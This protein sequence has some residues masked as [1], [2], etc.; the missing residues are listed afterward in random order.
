MHNNITSPGSGGMKE[1]GSSRLERMEAAVI[2]AEE[3]L[4][5]VDL[6]VDAPLLGKI[7]N[8][9]NKDRKNKELYEALVQLHECAE[10]TR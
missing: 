6:L 1:G 7:T 2:R 3:V 8:I 9:T 5:K 10:T 4:V